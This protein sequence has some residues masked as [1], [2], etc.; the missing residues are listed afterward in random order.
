M[1]GVG[2][3]GDGGGDGGG[4]GGGWMAA[5]GGEA[6]LATAGPVAA[7]SAVEDQWRRQGRAVSQAAMAVPRVGLAVSGH[8]HSSLS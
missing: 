3:A 4:G 6:A 1:G 7:V 5:A 2:G 8:V